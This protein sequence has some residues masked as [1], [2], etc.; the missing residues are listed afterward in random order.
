MKKV[1]LGAVLRLLP[2][3]LWWLAVAVFVLT[4]VTFVSAHYRGEVPR[5]FGYSIMNI[6]SDSME[7]EIMPGDYILIKKVAPEDVRERQV[8]CFYSTDPAIAGYP[9]THRVVAPPR[10]EDGEYYFTTK[11]DHNLAPDPVEAKGS[12][13]I[14]VYVRKLTVLTALLN[15][16]AGNRFAVLLIPLMLGAIV[17]IVATV[18]T[19]RTDNS[20]KKGPQNTDGSSGR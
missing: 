9:N 7:D 6:V 15:F 14:G 2:S 11:G 20:D 5:I 12:L 1:K 17:M 16:I 3:I 19:S 13:L 10:C 4:A 18:I 8:I